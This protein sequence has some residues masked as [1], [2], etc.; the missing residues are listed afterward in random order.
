[1]RREKC[2]GNNIKFDD[3]E[4]QYVIYLHRNLINGKVYIGQTTLLPSK[5][6]KN[7]KGY[8]SNMHLRSAINK[9]GWENFEHI[10]LEDFIGTPTQAANKEQQYIEIYNALDPEY[11]YNMKKGDVHVPRSMIEA[12]VEWMKEHPEFGLARAADMHRWQKEH[13]EEMAAITKKFQEAGAKAKMK[14]V[15]CVETGMI[16]ESQCEAARQVPGTAQSK[17]NMCCSG[18]RKTCGGYHWEYYNEVEQE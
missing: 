2:M 14:P 10:I 9:Y 7:G 13:P 1:M 4:R 15:R 5:R 17:I 6:W 12:S 8:P 11:G 3:T 18:G 16:F